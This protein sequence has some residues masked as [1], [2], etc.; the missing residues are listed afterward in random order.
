MDAAEFARAFPGP[1]PPFLAA[2]AWAMA[3]A[4]LLAS[5]RRGARSIT[6]WHGRNSETLSRPWPPAGLA[7][8]ERR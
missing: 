1:A 4:A 6:S 7:T 3:A 8:H 2:S 5:R